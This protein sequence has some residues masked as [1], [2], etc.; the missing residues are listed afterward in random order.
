MSRTSTDYR[1]KAAEQQSDV[2]EMTSGSQRTGRLIDGHYV[3]E[4]D[5]TV[6]SKKS[7]IARLLGLA[8][9][10]EKRGD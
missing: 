2:D 1:R 8:N 7:L 4:T 9:A 10:Y 6:T 5:E 3:D